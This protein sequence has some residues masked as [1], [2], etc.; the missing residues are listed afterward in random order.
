MCSRKLGTML[1][2][3]KLI[4]IFLVGHHEYFFSDHHNNVSILL[5]IEEEKCKTVTF[6]YLNCYQ[7]SKWFWTAVNISTAIKYQNV[8][9][10]NTCKEYD[11]GAN[12]LFYYWTRLYLNP[13]NFEIVH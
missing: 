2:L 5:F 10:V 4:W 12:L 1:D 9:L 8:K 6:S 7:A 3:G 13:S 11:F